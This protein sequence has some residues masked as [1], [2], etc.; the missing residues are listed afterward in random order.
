MATNVY[1]TQNMLNT[2]F[3][4]R[5]DIEILVTETNATGGDY[6]DVT[7]IDIYK[8]LYWFEMDMNE[9]AQKNVKYTYLWGSHSP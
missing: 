5:P 9:I 2:Y 6:P 7:S 4:N 1:N 8:A 3:T